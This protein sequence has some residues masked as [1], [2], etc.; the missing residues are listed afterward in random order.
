MDD[1]KKIQMFFCG[2]ETEMTTSLK[3]TDLY[4]FSGMMLLIILTTSS[5]QGCDSNILY[6]P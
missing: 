6:E 3:S 1:Y 5:D 4:H 2:Y